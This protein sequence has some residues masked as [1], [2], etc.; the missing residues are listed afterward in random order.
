[1]IIRDQDFAFFVFLG[2]ILCKGDGG[3]KSWKF[4]VS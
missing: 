2:V 3:L 4:A 1:M